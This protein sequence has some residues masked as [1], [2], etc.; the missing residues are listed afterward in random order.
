VGGDHVRRESKKIDPQF[1]LAVGTLLITEIRT[2]LGCS[3]VDPRLDIIDG[4]F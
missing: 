3:L 1:S 2:K 4:A